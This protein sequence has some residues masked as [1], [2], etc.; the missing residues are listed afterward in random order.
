MKAA[1]QPLWRS[2]RQWDGHDFPVPVRSTDQWPQQFVVIFS[3]Y[4]Q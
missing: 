3:V 2:F 4:S 1:T